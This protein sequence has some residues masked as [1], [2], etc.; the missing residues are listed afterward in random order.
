MIVKTSQVS[1][2]R[3]HHPSVAQWLSYVVGRRLPEDLNDWVRRDVTRPRAALRQVV[4]GE[5]VYCPAFV[6]LALLP[7]PP[8]LRFLVVLL[9]VVLSTFY[10]VAFLDQNRQ[11]RLEAQGLPTDL[12]SDREQRVRDKD[13]ATYESTYRD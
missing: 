6:A 8:G 9:G 3:L 11:R 7:G 13:R 10:G 1:L 5:L 2:D 4:R 12:V